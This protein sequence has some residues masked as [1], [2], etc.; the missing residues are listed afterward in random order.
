V[1]A[2]GVKLAG[3]CSISP[4]VHPDESLSFGQQVA[5]TLVPLKQSLMVIAKVLQSILGLIHR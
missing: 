4:L 1:G 2:R 3:S 5:H